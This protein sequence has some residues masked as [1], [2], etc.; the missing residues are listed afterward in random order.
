MMDKLIFGRYIPGDSIIH[1]L[2]P[3]AKLLASF[4][5]IGIIFLANNWQTYLFLFAFTMATIAL[6]KIK[7]KFFIN[8]VKPLIWLILF[9]VVLQVL[10][11]R[12]GEVYFEWGP[13]VISQFGLLNGV[14][15]FCRF[16]LIIFMSTLLTLTTAPLALT[17]AIEFLLRPLN[18]VKFPVHEIALMLSIALRFVPTLMDETEKIM[19]AQRARGVDFGEGNVF[20]QMKSIV[21]LLVP[22]FV[23][24]FNRAEELATAMEARGYQGGE[25]R[26]KYRLLKWKRNDTL[27]ILV[28]AVVTVLLVYLRT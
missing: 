10:F 21:P 23:S 14:F 8:G 6:S 27:V 17:D 22:L 3:R 12:G 9:T 11:S 19:N 5:F 20:Q 2:D 18:V 4:Y 15:I 1:R 26:T 24:S 13:I 16:V 7:Y 28:Y 25:G